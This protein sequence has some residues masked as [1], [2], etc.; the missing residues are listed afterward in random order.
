MENLQ[1]TVHELVDFHDSCFVSASVAIVRRAKNC[2][3]VAFVRPVIAIHDK[4]MGACNP[5]QAIGVVEL[6]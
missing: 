6:F 5:G 3:N 4:L 1:V 2:H